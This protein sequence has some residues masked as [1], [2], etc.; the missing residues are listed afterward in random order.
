MAQST[1][2]VLLVRFSSIGDI[3]LTAPALP[4]TDDPPQ[5]SIE[6]HFLTKRPFKG[7][8]DLLPG[9]HRVHTI[10]R[11]VHEV[12]PTLRSLQFHHVVDWHNNLRSWQ[13]QWG[14]LGTGAQFSRLDKF[15][16]RRAGLVLGPGG[17]GLPGVWER[18]LVSRNDGAGAIGNGIP[19]IVTRY[20]E[21][22]RTVRAAAGL[23]PWEAT[24]WP[25]LNRPQDPAGGD[26]ASPAGGNGG[27][28][29]VGLALG[30]AHP[31]KR[32]PLEN[33]ALALQ[34]LPPNWR[35]VLLGGPGDR[36]AAADLLRRLPPALQSA[37]TDLTGSTALPETAAWLRTMD[38]VLAGDTGLGHLTAA[39]GV[40]LVTVW[41]CTRPSLGMTPWWPAQGSISLEPT[42]RGDRPCSRLGDRCRR[43]GP[44]DPC[45]R[46]VAPQRIA[47]ALLH[48]AR[49]PTRP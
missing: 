1:L 9:V 26:S 35:F 38:V 33:L 42:G 24:P 13:L 32:I 36:P 41:G 18:W 37:T 23:P 17:M 16:W 12:L 8:A 4:R 44:T 27:G 5:A 2:R 34:S 48:A 7:A 20:A 15:R 11:S 40:P 43:G 21:A 49:S 30:A 14:M 46:H 39:L 47:A 45:I 22:T 6:L 25:T 10:E 3:L 28:V 29:V 19:H 31:L